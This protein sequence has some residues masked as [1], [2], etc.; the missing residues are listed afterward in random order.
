MSVVSSFGVLVWTGI[1]RRIRHSLVSSLMIMIPRLPFRNGF[2]TIYVPAGKVVLPTVKLNGI[3]PL[4]ELKD[5]APAG[6][7][8]SAVISNTIAQILGIWFFII[9]SYSCFWFQV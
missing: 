1:G 3:L 6:T 4:I 2:W 9:I 7:S 5:C 8:R